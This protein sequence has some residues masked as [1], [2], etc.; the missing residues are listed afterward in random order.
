[1]SGPHEREKGRFGAQAAYLPEGDPQGPPNVFHPRPE[2]PPGYDGYADPAEAHGWEGNAYDE[3]A[4]LPL[5]PDATE[6][7]EAPPAER[8]RHSR[9]GR[10]ARRSPRAAVLAAAVGAVALVGVIAGFAFSGSS[11]GG[12]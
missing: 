5:V 10:D 11:S 6:P 9:H 2:P 12:S 8:R 7:D 4:Q 1:M 3:T